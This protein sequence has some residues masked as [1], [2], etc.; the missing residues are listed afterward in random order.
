MEEG[1]EKFGIESLSIVHCVY[2]NNSIKD[3]LM[4]QF[5][6]H[7]RALKILTYI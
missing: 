2:I 4:E 5:R 3:K 7:Y 1:H 6:P